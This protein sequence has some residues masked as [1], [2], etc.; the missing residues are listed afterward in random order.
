MPNAYREHR[1]LVDSLMKSPFTLQQESTP[2]FW[3]AAHIALGIMGEGMEYDIAACRG[4]MDNAQEELGDLL[5]FLSALE[6]HYSFSVD[7][8]SVS[9]YSSP[10]YR[11]VQEAAL[12]LGDQLKKVAIYKKH[13]PVNEIA[14]N[15]RRLYLLIHRDAEAMGTHPD[16]LREENTLKLRKRYP[17]GSFSNEAASV[18]ADKEY[19][20][21]KRGSHYSILAVKLFHFGRIP[22][23]DGTHFSSDYIEPAPLDGTKEIRRT[24]PIYM[25]QTENPLT[26]PVKMVFYK[27]RGGDKHFARPLEEFLDGRFEEVV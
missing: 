19:R 26:G 11:T 7:A 14:L 22:V 13:I 27:E 20:H 25:L 23:N 5:F 3:D 15:A 18:R 16:R 10:Y 4:D 24:L 2:R 6:T 8:A 21:K 1:H 9:D 17:S 12:A